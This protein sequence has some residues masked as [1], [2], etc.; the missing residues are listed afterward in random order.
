MEKLKKFNYQKM[1]STWGRYSRNRG[2]V[3]P[4]GE[5]SEK[6]VERAREVADLILWKTNLGL[7]LSDMNDVYWYDRLWYIHDDDEL[8]ERL[9]QIVSELVEDL[10]GSMKEKR[11]FIKQIYDMELIDGKIEKTPV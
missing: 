1:M 8:F 2:E 4:S 10:G 3:T 5:P 11:I 7:G 9:Q 6:L